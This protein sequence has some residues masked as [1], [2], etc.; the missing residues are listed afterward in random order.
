M[1]DFQFTN[2][3]FEVSDPIPVEYTCDGEDVS[4]PLEWAA[5][6][7]GTESLVLIVDDPDAPVPS[8]F[9]HWVLFN[10]PPDAEELPRNYRTEDPHPAA[11]GLEPHA[12]RNDFGDVGYGGPCPPTGETHRYVFTLYALDTTLDLDPG[13]Q[14]Q[15][16][17]DA[18]E[19]HVLAEAEHVGTYRRPGE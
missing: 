15:A 18:M 12:G 9:T 14:L 6:P 7:D 19:G 3:P 13:V 17:T 8:A 10:L 16:V 1:A 11:D 2:V 5:S 4:P